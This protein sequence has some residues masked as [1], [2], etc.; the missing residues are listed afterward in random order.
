MRG[1]PNC[2]NCGYDPT[3]DDDTFTSGGG[4]E[5]SNS[6]SDG[7]WSDELY[8]PVCEELVWKSTEDMDQRL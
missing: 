8:C 6:I 5:F 1:P 7:H 3:G 4:W 2:P